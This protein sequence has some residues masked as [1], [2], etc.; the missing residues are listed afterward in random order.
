ML[1]I[2]YATT[3]KN[4][5]QK[6]TLILLVQ[7]GISETAKNKE[8]IIMLWSSIFMTNS[9]ILRL[10]FLWDV[11]V[12]MLWSKFNF[13]MRIIVGYGLEK[14]I[15]CSIRGCNILVVISTKMEYS[16]IF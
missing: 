11:K 5:Y 10:Y 16:L 8:K 14:Y 7:F 3:Y 13:L 12:T 2:R 1:N 9:E 4:I 6:L 15:F